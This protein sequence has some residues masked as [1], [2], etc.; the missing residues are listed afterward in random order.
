MTILQEDRTYRTRDGSRTGIRVKPRWAADCF[1]WQAV[2]SYT[3]KDIWLPNGKWTNS[4]GFDHK[5]DLIE[6][7]SAID[8]VPFSYSACP[9]VDG[10]R[11]AVTQ[12]GREVVLIA[13]DGPFE[14]PILGFYADRKGPG[15]VSWCADGTVH[16]DGTYSANDLLVPPLP[17]CV[18]WI[19]LSETG[20][21][22]T[23]NTE[24]EADQAATG[25]KRLGNK[26]VPV[27]VGV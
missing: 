3:A 7:T 9:I 23:F 18:V 13:S 15:A 19:N 17:K 25:C 20:G 12:D 26:A 24:E 2:E 27:E 14:R 22:N 5:G 6:E 16:G 4:S 1:K 21:Y 8:P 11:R 10:R